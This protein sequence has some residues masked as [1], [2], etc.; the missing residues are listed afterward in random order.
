MSLDSKVNILLVDDHVE[1]L[2][3]LEAILAGMGQNLVRASSGEEALRW[4][5][6]Q[7]FAVILLDVQMPGMDGF[8]T[9]MLIRQRERSQHTPIIFLTAFYANDVSQLKGYAL[10]AV[11]YLLKP[12]DPA[13]LTSKVTVFVDLFKKTQEIQ[14]QTAEL[15]A[16]KIEIIREQLARQQA[17]AASRMKD[18]FLAIVSHELRTPLNSILG[19]SKL[20]AA[21]KLDKETSDR[22]LE[23][24]SRN[25]QSQAKLIDD[26][27]D[28][29]R[30][31]RGKLR[32]LRQP[33]NL[34]NLIAA[35]LESI[36]P[37]ADSKG[38]QISG[39][40]TSEP[41]F[42]TGDPQ[43]LQQILRN[44]LS[45]AIKFTPEG[46]Q[47]EVQLERRNQHNEPTPPLPNSTL[48]EESLYQPSNPPP[49]SFEP[50]LMAHPFEYVQVTVKDTGIGIDAEFLPYIF[51][52]FRQADS[53][54]TRAHNGLGLGLAIVRQLVDL[55]GGKIYAFS[56]GTGKGTTFMIHLPLQNVPEISNPPTPSHS[57]DRDCKDN[58]SLE[59]ISIL[60]VDDNTDNRDYITMVLEKAGAQVTA[61]ANGYE[62][63]EFLQHTQPDILLSDIA[64]PE[65]DGYHL[66][67]Q[68]REF[69]KASN[70]HIPVIALTAYAKQED[71]IQALTAGF[72]HFIPKPVDPTELVEVVA[73]TVRKKSISDRL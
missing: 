46:G 14:R 27:L 61:L 22:A 71:R 51:E 49:P 72:E 16:K 65:V 66:L 2:I 23:I 43:R 37:S 62:V 20:L 25:A 7:D 29:A 31:M 54:S 21:N 28:V 24:I 68:I 33:V 8:E 17:E 45:N 11:D 53:S 6:N 70:T 1:N 38:I 19:W 36:R 73:C 5:L 69:E 57:S 40:L 67:Y 52:Y 9:A 13:I 63:I 50:S 55:H 12:I 42:I 59:N 15:A 10:G 34:G 4:L 35:E 48:D 56:E 64:M 32:L 18:E 26:I 58:P 30:L 47:I 41:C 3:A 44:L 60:I 39:N